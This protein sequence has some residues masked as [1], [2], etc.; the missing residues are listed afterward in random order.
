VPRTDYRTMP[1]QEPSHHATHTLLRQSRWV[2]T[3]SNRRRIT[4]PIRPE[5]AVATYVQR[6]VR[7]TIFRPEPDSEQVQPADGWTRPQEM[8]TPGPLRA[9]AGAGGAARACCNQGWRKAEATLRA[10]ANTARGAGGAGT[11]AGV[12]VAG[13]A[14]TVQGGRGWD[15]A[16]QGAGGERRRHADAERA[17]EELV[18]HARG[19]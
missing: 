3:C 6:R 4:I 9:C 8:E 2:D 5:A 11:A 7:A 18:R 15:K 10:G 13:Q 19:T 17:G 16:D 12:A 14:T 1:G